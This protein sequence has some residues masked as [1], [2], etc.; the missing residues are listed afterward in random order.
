M[1]S[2]IIK[3]DFFP[4]HRYFRTT[5]AELDV[6]FGHGLQEAAYELNLAVKIAVMVSF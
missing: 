5:V 3:S 2:L 6:D 4:S 1:S